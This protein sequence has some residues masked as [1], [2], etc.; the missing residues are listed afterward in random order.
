[1]PTLSESIYTYLDGEMDTDIYWGQLPADI[2]FSSGV[3]NFYELPGLADDITWMSNTQYQFSIRHNDI[4]SAYNI[5]EELIKILLGK[6]GDIGNYQTQFFFGNTQGELYED[7]GRI[8]H[9]P[10]I[11]NIRYIR[12]EN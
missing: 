11:T 3:I 6:T 5:R 8:I 4:R 1:M 10:I 12:F 7:E 2:D 9:L